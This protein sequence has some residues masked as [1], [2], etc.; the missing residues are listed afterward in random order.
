[1]NA[2]RR[3]LWFLVPALALAA[4]ETAAPPSTDSG[5][6]T[7]VVMPGDVSDAASAA[8]VVDAAN[9]DRPN[10]DVPNTDVPNTDVPNTDVPNTD[11]PNTDAGADAGV[12]C[13]ALPSDYVPRA[14]MPAM[15]MWPTCISD[16]N[17]Y[18]P[19]NMSIGSIGR[20]LSFELMNRDMAMGRPN[21]FFDPARDPSA[22]EFTAARL[23][24]AQDNGLGSRIERRSD[25]HY[26]APTPNDCQM[27]V[28]RTANPDYCVGPMRLLPLINT[29][30][31]AGQMGGMG[32]A[33]RVHAARI[34]AAL[35]WFLYVSPYK[36]SLT[37]TTTPA[38]CDSGWAYYTGGQ[39]DRASTTQYA[40]ARAVRALEPA[41]H[42][43]I[44]DG[45]L[46]VRCWKDAL[47]MDTA[48]RD[49]ARAQLDRGLTR[50]IVALLNSHV[51]SVG[52]TTGA[53]RDAH[54]AWV[55]VVGPLMD[56]AVRA[57]DVTAA[58]ALQT[59]FMGTDPGAFPGAMVTA[60]LERLFPCP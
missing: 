47:P 14:R 58:N 13:M 60:T 42:D 17:T 31:A 44:W 4:C 57:L 36:E 43:R 15:P 40:F 53:E 39:Y 2:P 38:D 20:T 11:V 35:M 55:K 12:A 59:A 29:A 21:A 16:D 5:T 9:T 8:D 34:E 25:E 30:F 23:I 48:A 27:E 32:T 37:C 56:R 19:I 10:T 22:E 54:F 28:V 3:P 41:T 33:N 45:L 46:A 50:G 49:R 1:M 7:D 51:R 52:T 26:P 24:Y 6:S 18:H